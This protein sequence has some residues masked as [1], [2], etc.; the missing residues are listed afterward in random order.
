MAKT[1]LIFRTFHF[2]QRAKQN[3]SISVRTGRPANPPADHA[4]FM[5]FDRNK[6]R[7]RVTQRLST[8]AWQ[9]GQT[10][11]FCAIFEQIFFALLGSHQ[12]YHRVNYQIGIFGF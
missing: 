9:S 12:K 6:G 11:R 1:S 10:L 4:R 8:I 7:W 3:P 2:T 5:V